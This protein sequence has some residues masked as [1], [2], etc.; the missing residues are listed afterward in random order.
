MKTVK[1]TM[2]ASIAAAIAVPATAHSVRS[3][4]LRGRTGSR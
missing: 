1:L 4:R 2:L 3:T